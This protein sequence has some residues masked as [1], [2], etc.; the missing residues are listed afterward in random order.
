MIRCL[1]QEF[2]C[3][4]GNTWGQLLPHLPSQTNRV[5]ARTFSR[6]LFAHLYITTGNSN[7]QHW[8][9]LDSQP[10]DG[11][12]SIPNVT[13]ELSWCPEVLNV[14]FVVTCSPKFSFINLLFL[15]KWVAAFFQK[16]ISQIKI[17]NTKDWDKNRTPHP[18]RGCHNHSVPH[19]LEWLNFYR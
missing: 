4:V 18:L 8:N 9:S 5:L 10:S 3:T 2:T 12:N 13:V 17:R 1:F 11:T 19:Y 7:G 15:V 16:P 6:Q 14:R